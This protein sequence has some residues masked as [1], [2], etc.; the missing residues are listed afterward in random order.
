MRELTQHE[1]RTAAMAAAHNAFYQASVLL[2][3]AM[4]HARNAGFSCSSEY[5]TLRPELD[6]LQ[7]R[8]DT[9]KKAVADAA[10]E[11]AHG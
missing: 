10:M 4:D 7:A 1:W 9:A 8:L 6:R 5:K 2:H 3:E 11:V